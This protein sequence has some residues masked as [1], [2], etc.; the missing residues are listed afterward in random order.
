MV[1][2]GP[3]F[4]A[5]SPRRFISANREAMESVLANTGGLQGSLPFSESI[6]H[7]KSQ[8]SH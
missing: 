5:P 8:H 2:A 7:G 6:S 4:S 3:E 1:L